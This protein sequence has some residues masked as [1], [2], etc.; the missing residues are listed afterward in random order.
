MICLNT[1]R[2]PVLWLTSCESTGLV[3][4]GVWDN[5]HK[6]TGGKL[7]SLVDRIILTYIHFSII[8]NIEIIISSKLALGYFQL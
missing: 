2:P 6:T 4:G 8:R 1:P 3:A 7:F 5:Y